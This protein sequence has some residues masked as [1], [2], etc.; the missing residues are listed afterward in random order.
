MK[1][2]EWNEEK[3]RKGKD[4]RKLL[5]GREKGRERRDKSG[6]WKGRAVSGADGD[7]EPRHSS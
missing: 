5:E 6:K 3:T 2:D 4:R 1:E 7:I